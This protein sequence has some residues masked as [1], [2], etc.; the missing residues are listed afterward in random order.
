VFWEPKEPASRTYSIYSWHFLQM[1][2]GS[3]SYLLVTHWK[4]TKRKGEDESSVHYSF[5]KQCPD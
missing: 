4:A 3:F 2:L 5:L 1:R